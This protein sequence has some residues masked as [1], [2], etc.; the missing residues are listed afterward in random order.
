MDKAQRKGDSS[1][2]EQRVTEQFR[3]V[4][5]D[6]DDA[7]KALAT[8]LSIDGIKEVAC[9]GITI[10][11]V[12]VPYKQISAFQALQSVIVPDLE[13]KLGNVQIVVVGKRRAFPKTPAHKRRYEAV[14]SN[15]R[16]LRSVQEGLLNDVCYP[17]SIVGKRIHYDLKGKQKTLVLLDPHDRTRVE[18]RLAGFG[19]AFKRLTGIQTVFQFGG[20]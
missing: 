4:V 12:T 19:A 20:Q 7:T 2:L 13:K 3:A 14:R 6:M 15:G 16:T 9:D 17:T 11:I 18:E 1:A 5:A 8:P 10:L